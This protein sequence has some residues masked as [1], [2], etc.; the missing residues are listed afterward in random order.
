[1]LQPGLPDRACA[2]FLDFDGTLVDL[3][4]RPEAV[5]LHPALPGLLSRLRGELDGA[6][7]IVSGRTVAEI[8][9]QLHPLTLCTAGVH[10]VERRGV[11][12]YIR[13]IAI[14]EM[15]DAV[16]LIESLCRRH[17]ALHMEDKRGAIALHYRQAPEL[18]D[19]CLAVMAQAIA[20]TNGMTLLRGKKVVEMKPQRAN[21]GLAVRTFMDERGFRMRRP[22][23]FGDDVTDESA[24]EL[25]Q[26]MGGVAV[27]VGEG[28][29]LAAHRLPDPAA[30][31]VWL[32][33]A[34]AALEPRGVSGAMP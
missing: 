23:Y 32:E 5:R 30:V 26:A 22:W 33:Q 3:A 7:A 24:F 2:V 17:P 34:V 16:A 11:D 13:R 27:K 9:A 18:E 15:R 6:L 25:V 14:G 19:E 1:M 28:E 20:R 31:R 12:G 4:P 8:D 29:T 10:G 21:K